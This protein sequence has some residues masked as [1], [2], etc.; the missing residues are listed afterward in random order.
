[1]VAAVVQFTLEFIIAILRLPKD[2]HGATSLSYDPSEPSSR[3]EDGRLF[4]QQ[5]VFYSTIATLVTSGLTWIIYKILT[6]PCRRRRDEPPPQPEEN[7]PPRANPVEPATLPAA[8][9]TTNK[10]SKE[11]TSELSSP[12][13]FAERRP[14]AGVDL[15][16]YEM[17]T[18]DIVDRNKKLN[19]SYQSSGN[20]A[21]AFKAGLV[22]TVSE[23][24]TG[25]NPPGDPAKLIIKSAITQ[26]AGADR[27]AVDRH[28]AAVD[29]SALEYKR[30]NRRKPA[31]RALFS[32][33]HNQV[34]FAVEKSRTGVRKYD[35]EP[36][37]SKYNT[38]HLFVYKAADHYKT[39]LNDYYENV[40]NQHNYIRKRRAD[41]INND[42]RRLKKARIER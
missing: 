3:V 9:D 4:I 16:Q 1:M 39:D 35:D 25:V 17:T 19:P 20:Y 18:S 27:T 23:A 32:L 14:P 26:D 22:P 7:A 40:L 8:I 21:Q 29:E 15:D 37:G 38:A 13:P 12:P 41:Y 28:M 11:T 2:L 10:V 30:R 5:D 31:G 24:A 33:I 42:N 36:M 6:A 34:V